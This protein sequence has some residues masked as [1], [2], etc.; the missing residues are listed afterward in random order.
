MVISKKEM[1]VFVFVTLALII[2]GNLL[3][4]ADLAYRAVKWLISVVK[5]EY[6]LAMLAGIGIILTGGF[7]GILGSCYR[8]KCRTEPYF[9]EWWDVVIFGGA[10]AA[11]SFAVIVIC[12]G[13][14]LIFENTDPFSQAFKLYGLTFVSGFFAMRLLPCFGSMMEKRMGELTQ[15][16]T[17]SDRRH[18]EEMRRESLLKRAEIALG[19][20]NRLDLQNAIACI[21]DAILESPGDRTLNIYCG[22]LYRE[23]KEYSKAVDVLRKYCKHLTAGRT[24]STLSEEQKRALAV[25]MFNIACYLCLE[26]EGSKKE[27]L[28][29]EARTTLKESFEFDTR[30]ENCWKEDKD[31]KTLAEKFSEL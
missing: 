30:Y 24:K 4:R 14:G 18:E 28:L 22:R 19:R 27:S 31:L 26:Y 11:S 6:W 15:R 2:G 25:A 8:R 23:L 17:D 3:L 10:G 16:L 21:E 12:K 20:R 13:L 7:G 5:Q 29:S 9:Q 1:G